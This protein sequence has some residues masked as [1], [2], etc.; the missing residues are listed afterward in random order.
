[1]PTMRRHNFDLL[2]ILSCFFAIHYVFHECTLY[3]KP[4]ILFDTTSATLP[5]TLI[6]MHAKIPL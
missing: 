1:M 3:L 2:G 5:T 6:V 4:K